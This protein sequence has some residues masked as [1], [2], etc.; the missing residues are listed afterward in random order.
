MHVLQAHTYA[1][2]LNICVALIVSM[3]VSYVCMYDIVCTY[4]LHALIYLGV[5]CVYIGKSLLSSK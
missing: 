1:Y 2:A 5:T 3:Y 4:A